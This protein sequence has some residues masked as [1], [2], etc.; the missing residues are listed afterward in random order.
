MSLPI[1]R[2]RRASELVRLESEWHDQQLAMLLCCTRWIWVG[3]P[4]SRDPE[5]RCDAIVV[6]QEYSC[7][8]VF[9]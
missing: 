1:R 3:E 2:P 5:F 8:L 6:R 4:E 7:P 9:V